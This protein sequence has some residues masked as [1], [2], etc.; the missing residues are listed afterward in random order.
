MTTVVSAKQRETLMK[1]EKD[2]G[3]LIQ[4]SILAAAGIVTKIIGVIYK[5]PLMNTLGDVGWGTFMNA[6]NVYNIALTFS[7]NSMPMAISKLLSASIASGNEKKTQKVFYHSS[8]FGVILGIIASLILFFGAGFFE[9]IKQTSG[10]AES[11]QVLSFTVFVVTL[12]GLFRGYFQGHGNMVPTS[13][14]QVIEQIVN[15]VTANICVMV[16]CRMYAGS[17]QLITKGA[18]GACFGT[19]AGAAAALMFLVISY[20]RFR[21]D[22]RDELR[23]SEDVKENNVLIYRAIILTI[24]PMI[25]SQTVYQIGG[26]FDDII[27]KFNLVT[28]KYYDQR[29]ATALQGFFSGQYSQL[30]N[31]PIAVASALAVTLLPAITYESSKGNIKARDAKMLSV[32]KLTSLLAFPGA[33]GIGVMARPIIMIL[34]RGI[35]SEEWKLNLVSGLLYCGF[36][37]VITYSFS[38]VTTSILQGSG[39]MKK[40]VIN[41]AVSL[42]IH[43]VLVFVLTRYTTLDAYALV[44]ADV[45]FPL[46][47]MILNIISMKKYLG[48]SLDLKKVFLKPFISS[49][50]MD[51]ICFGAYRIVLMLSGMV[52]VSFTAAVIMAVVSYFFLIF[53][54]K[55]FTRDEIFELPMG[56]TIISKFHIAE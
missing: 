31:I 21:R 16:F 20:I 49:A 7:Y 41:C 11:L 42:V 6:F 28:V 45:L 3:L 5:L 39:Y 43:L 10:I 44:I 38:T 29:D 56:R 14:S 47:I 54:T 50:A 55:Y 30:V 2:S 27:F 51:V 26:F 17:D 32:L 15:A 53:K 4:G 37:S 24:I 34:F 52:L 9:K 35:A 1:K 36:L 25:I 19:L 46:I 33:V 23:K 48:Y 13:V 40:P 8:V 18:M 12:L 22:R